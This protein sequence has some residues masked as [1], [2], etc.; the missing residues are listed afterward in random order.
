MLLKSLRYEFHSPFVYSSLGYVYRDLGE[1]VK[2]CSLFKRA[3][4]KQKSPMIAF[5]L[6]KLLAE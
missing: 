3:L 2:A 6:G 4:E 1:S 5:E